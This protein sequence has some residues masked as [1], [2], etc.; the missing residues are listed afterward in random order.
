MRRCRVDEDARMTR[1]LRAA[2]LINVFDACLCCQLNLHR[3][4]PE[5]I[6]VNFG[7]RTCA[8]P[9][10]RCHEHMELV[11]MYS[12]AWGN[13]C[14]SAVK[15]LHMMRRRFVFRRRYAGDGPLTCVKLYLDYKWKILQLILH[16]GHVHYLTRRIA[17]S[18]VRCAHDPTCGAVRV[19]S[20]QT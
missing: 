17:P 19:V 9:Y 6:A 10:A 5:D 4:L 15:L 3:P 7:L 20:V 14:P 11:K 18:R 2:P 8:L 16:C 12:Y 13:K 1:G